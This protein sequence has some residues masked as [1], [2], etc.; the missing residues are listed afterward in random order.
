MHSGK[1]Y[2]SYCRV[3]YANLEQSYVQ[4]CKVQQHRATVLYCAL[5]SA[6]LQQCTVEAAVS[7]RCCAVLCRE[8][9]SQDSEQRDLYFRRITAGP[10][11][12]RL[13][14]FSLQHLFSAQHRSVTRQNRQRLL[15]S[16]SL[17]ERF[18]QD[19][20][21]H[22]PSNYQ[23]SRPQQEMPTQSASPDVIHLDEELRQDPEAEEKSFESSESVEES[24]AHPGVSQNSAKEVLVRPSVIQKL[25]RGQQLSLELNKIESGVRNI[26]LV[27]IGHAS[28]NGKSVIRPSVIFNAPPATCLPVAVRARPVA[29]STS[30]IPLAIRSESRSKHNPSKV[31]KVEQ[32]DGGSKNRMPS[33]RPE[34][35]SVPSENPKESNKKSVRVNLNNKLL[36]QKDVKCQGETS[37]PASKFREPKDTKSSVRV[38]SS[39]KVAVNPVVKLKKPDVP[40]AKRVSEGAIP[41]RRG[42]LPSQRSCTREEKHLVHNKPASLKQKG[43]VSAKAKL[44]RSSLQS[45]SVPARKAVQKLHLWKGKPGAH[46]DGSRGSKMNVD[47]NSVSPSSAHLSDM[48]ARKRNVSEETQTTSQ[49]KSNRACDSKI[50]SEDECEDSLQAVPNQS[51][52]IVK[53]ASPPEAI[54]VSLV[55][56]CYDSSDSEM[57]FDCD[58]SVE[59]TDINTQ[60]PDVDV[61]FPNRVCINL[62][63]KSYGSSSSKGSAASLTSRESVVKK[64]PGDVTKKKQHTKPHIWL[65]DKSYGSSYSASSSD[66]DGLPQSGVDCPQPIVTEENQKGRPVQLK[67]KKCKPSSAKAH[68]ACGVSHE[69]VS[70]QPQSDVGRKK[71]LKKKNAGLVDMNCESYDPDMGFHADAQLVADESQEAVKEVNSQAVDTDLENKS[72]QSSISDLSFESHDCLYQSANDELEGDLGEINLKELNVDVEAKSSGSCSSELTFDSDSPLSVSEWSQLDVESL[73][74]DPF[75]L[76]EESSESNSSGLTFDSDIPTCSVIDQPEVAVYEEEPVDLE[77]ES[78]ESCVSEISFDSDIPLHSGKEQPEVAVKEVIIQEEEY[79]SLERKNAKP[80][81]SEINSDFYTPLHSVTNPPQVAMRE[82]SSQELKHKENKPTDSELSLNHDIFLS[83]IGHSEDLTD[84]R[85]FQKEDC[86]YLENK[87]D[88]PSVSGTQGD[89]D[90]RPSV[91]SNPQ[92][93][94]ENTQLHK[95]KQADVQGKNAEFNASEIKAN[96]PDCPVTEPQVFRKRKEKKKHIEKKTD[97]YDDFELT[98]NSDDFPWLVPENSPL[99]VFQE[100]F[101]YPEYESS[102]CSSLEANMDVTG[103]IHS[104]S[105]QPHLI[106][107]KKKYVDPKDKSSKPSDSEICFSSVQH[108]LPKQYH[109]MIST[110]NLWKEEAVTL[111]RKTEVPGCSKATYNSDALLTSAA[112]QPGVAV[113]LI[114]QGQEGQ[115]R[116]GNKIQSIFSEMNLDSDF[117]VQAIV[118][119]PYIAVQK[120]R[121]EDQPDQSGD[122]EGNSASDASVQPVAN[123]LGETGKE[124][125]PGN[126]EGVDIDSK[127]GAAESFEITRDSGVLQPATGQIKVIQEVK[128]W[129]KHLD[130]EDENGEPSGSK[131]NSGSNELSQ[132][133]TNK[134][135]QLIKQAILPGKGHFYLGKGYEPDGSEV[136]YISN[137]PLRPVIQ[138]PQSSEEEHANL[139]MNSSDACPSTSF[140][141]DTLCQ[142]VPGQLQKTVEEMNLKEV[143]VCLENKSYHLVGFKAGY[144]SDVP[145]QFVVDSSYVSAKEID[146]QKEDH[147]DL[148]NESYKAYCSEI[149]YDS[150]IHLQSEV[151]LPQVTSNETSFQSRGLLDMEENTYELSG[152]EMMCDSD[153]SFQIIV[154]QSQFSDGEADSPE[155]EFVDMRVSDSDCDREVIC[156]P[157]DPPQL[158]MGETMSMNEESFQVGKSYCHFCGSELTYEAAFQ[159]ATDQSTKAFRIINREKDCIIL[160]NCICQACGCEVDVNATAYNLSVSYQSQGPGQESF[161]SG[162]KSQGSDGPERNFY[163]EG[164]SQKTDSEVSLQKDPNYTELNDKSW[165][166]SS[167]FAVDCAT[168]AESEIHGTADQANPLKLKCADSASR[169]GTSY[170][171]QVAFQRGPSVQANTKRRRRAVKKM[172]PRKRVTF[173]SREYCYY[174][175]SSGSVAPP[176][177][178]LNKEPEVIEDDPSESDLEVLP[179][180]SPSVV[181]QTL[182]QKVRGNDNKT[183]YPG[184]RRKRGPSRRRS[185][186]HH[187]TKKVL[188]DEE[189]KP[190]WPSSDQNTT[191]VQTLPDSDN[192]ARETAGTSDISVASDKS[193]CPCPVAR[194]I[195]KKNQPQVPEDQASKATNATQTNR[196][197]CPLKRKATDPEEESP[198]R[199]CLQSNKECEPD[200]AVETAETPTSSAEALESGQPS[201][202]VPSS[203]GTKWKKGKF[204]SS[205]KR[206]QSTCGNRSKNV[207]KR[208]QNNRKKPLRKKAAVSRRRKAVVRGANTSKST[209]THNGSRKA[210]ISTARYSLKSCSGSDEPCV[211]LESMDNM[212]M[213]QPPKVSAFQLMPSNDD[214]SAS[215]EPVTDEYFESE[216]E[217]IPEEMTSSPES[218]C[219]TVIL[220][221]NEETSEKQSVLIRTKAN[222]VIKKYTFKYSV[223]VGPKSQTRTTLFEVNS[224]EETPDDV[225]LKMKPK[226]SSV[227]SAQLKGRVRAAAGRSKKKGLRSSSTGGRNKVAD[228]TYTYKMKTPMLVRE[229]NLRSS[230]GGPTDSRRMTRLSS[231]QN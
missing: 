227:P 20:L 133:V 83:T 128:P 14:C 111:Q 115:V 3:T 2:C 40:P 95:E 108:L 59:P 156:D 101:F 74:E 148:E 54:R 68:L 165:D 79:I 213:C 24:R 214:A 87:H 215:P 52:V 162:D 7:R 179:P 176:T 72:V 43:S 211:F 16:S 97:K 49:Y 161:P 149:Q 122:S 120:S 110:L 61:I 154:N 10:G 207:G 229:Y 134:I 228:K 195:L 160:G 38:K 208:K 175:S 25:E 50:N 21:L 15:S 196:E 85:N 76:E 190:A 22:H 164:T 217:K 163:F 187:S 220:E 99:G 71:L 205:R 137:V 103:S 152:L 81:G 174:L 64:P 13:P 56:E 177:K 112:D 41:K 185:Y 216:S 80:S 106:F 126:G 82:L 129:E 117:L 157:D 209:D 171:P 155:V 27:D 9:T 204:S 123:R 44:D 62:V 221:E 5:Q 26:N 145:V 69:A 172:H 96:V 28:N 36:Y 142:S 121:K 199:R 178:N 139:E 189:T 191:S 116:L 127:R 34:T 119:R 169:R 102:Q 206:K 94:V 180:V 33:C 131:I 170:S 158:T 92:V 132:T 192:V 84:D 30:R 114:I 125:A 153:V 159:S 91:I 104:V 98:L 66:N 70:H 224:E 109:K 11:G 212:N 124:T 63:D 31:D 89:S 186:K 168:S 45:A 67:N 4:S 93:V 218:I 42:E 39:S 107:F 32:L 118:D 29:A 184:K 210:F 223:L 100:D 173:D 75:N 194:D 135:Q 200:A 86:E 219:E 182:P 8:N 77:N 58:T 202:P 12:A 53:A 203:S 138:Q 57:N 78:D 55:D 113:Q 147:N 193:D 146:V 198:K 46:E 17:M 47:Y 183:N 48:T 130:L 90:I 201:S 51:Q 230:R 65:V 143:H 166:S 225:S 1:G 19:V 136:I 88:Q 18:L 150:G 188:L 140:D 37:S 35:P 6:E 105:D 73:K 144:N 226:N 60:Q 197:K 181:G 222:T 151:D 231:K 23:D 167:G 141:S